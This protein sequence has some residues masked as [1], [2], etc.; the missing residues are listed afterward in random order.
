[1][2]SKKAV[3][4]FF[5]KIAK[6]RTYSLFFIILALLTGL[7]TFVFLFWSMA[8]YLT[9]SSNRRSALSVGYSDSTQIINFLLL[10]THVNFRN[11]EKN[12]TS[13]GL[14]CL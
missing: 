6:H 2:N 13:T 1:M 10:L 5:N 11:I 12:K 4:I 14:T 9:L 7:F 8:P 3:Q